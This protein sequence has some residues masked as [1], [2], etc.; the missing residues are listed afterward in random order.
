ML[1]GGQILFI[2]VVYYN[3][4]VGLKGEMKVMIIDICESMS[5]YYAWSMLTTPNK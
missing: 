2:H 3:F 4:F 1:T 5:L